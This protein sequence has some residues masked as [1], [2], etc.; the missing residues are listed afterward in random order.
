M[1]L[2]RQQLKASDI[3]ALLLDT[4][5][6]YRKGKITDATAYKEAFL[7]GKIIDAIKIT[8]LESKIENLK[9]IL[10]NK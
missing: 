2:N 10:K 5:A 6:R 4:Y 8:E 1:N 9:Q 7:L 3:K